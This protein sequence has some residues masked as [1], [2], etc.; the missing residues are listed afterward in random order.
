MS[1]IVLANEYSP[2]RA[3]IERKPDY[4]SVHTK[5]WLVPKKKQKLGVERQLKGHCSIKGVTYDNPED[6]LEAM[7]KDTDSKLERYRY[8]DQESFKNR[9]KQ[10][11]KGIWSHLLVKQVLKLNKNLLVEDAVALPG[12]AGFYKMVGSEKKFTGASFRKGLVPEFTII[13]TDAADLP[14]EFTYGWRT[15]LMRLMKS[16][17]LRYSQINKVWGEVHF[18]DARGKHWNLNVR[19]FRV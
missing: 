9:E 5:A 7:W 19:E 2:L 12:C 8:P 17:D 11:G 15:V 10:T 6:M 16:G 13:K 4:G 18:G 1:S 14:V 3:A